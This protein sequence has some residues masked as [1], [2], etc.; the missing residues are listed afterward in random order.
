[1]STS[2]SGVSSSNMSYE[3]AM[4]VAR[5]SQ[6]QAKAEGAAINQLI[7]S[8]GEVADQTAAVS[9][10]GNPAPWGN[11]CGNCLDKLG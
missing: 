10:S 6:D 9:Q 4:R 7:Q 1:M 8:A 5:L 2:L 11:S 3:I